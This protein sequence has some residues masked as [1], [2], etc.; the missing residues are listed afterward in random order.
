ME[1]GWIVMVIKGENHDNALLKMFTLL[2]QV[3]KNDISVL[4]T[5]H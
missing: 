2:Y 1:P 3:L 4:D 5:I